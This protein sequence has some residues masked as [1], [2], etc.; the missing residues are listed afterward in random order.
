MAIDPP[1]RLDP[2][3]NIVEVGWGGKVLVLQNI[4]GVDAYDW[5]VG[6][7]GNEFSLD[8]AATL[9]SGGRTILS[10]YSNAHSSVGQDIKTAWVIVDLSAIE[11]ASLLIDFL[12]TGD[13]TGSP[14][15]AHADI[16]KG[17]A[18][19]QFQIVANLPTWDFE[20][21]A[22]EWNFVY[23]GDLHSTLEVQIASNS[24]VWGYGS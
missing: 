16:Y 19:S 21:E 3:E 18:F 12:A 9:T 8:A 20:P 6:L 7:L 1:W 23:G 2:H 10:I 22:L 14:W 4:Y 15:E 24:F 13:N 11:G 17:H 5:N